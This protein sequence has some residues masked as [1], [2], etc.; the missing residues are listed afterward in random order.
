MA[1]DDSRRTEADD[2]PQ[3]GE[4][5][6]LHQVPVELTLDADDGVQEEAGYGYGV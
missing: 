3:D 1:E 2:D 4:H 5:S 6:D